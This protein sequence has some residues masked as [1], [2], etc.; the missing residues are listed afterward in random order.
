MTIIKK[1]PFGRSIGIVWTAYKFWT[2]I[3]AATISLLLGHLV[4]SNMHGPDYLDRILAG[5]VIPE[6]LLGLVVFP[7]LTIFIVFFILMRKPR[8]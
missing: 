8:K 3:F 4:L 2:I 5:E 7:M 6:A 1:F